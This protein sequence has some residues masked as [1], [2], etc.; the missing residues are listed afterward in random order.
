MVF[1][2]VICRQMNLSARRYTPANADIDSIIDVYSVFQQ[3]D[4]PIE[5]IQEFLW[6]A[7]GQYGLRDYEKIFSAQ[8]KDDIF[9]ERQIDRATGCMV[10][11]RPDQHI[12]HVLPLTAHKELSVFFEGFMM[13]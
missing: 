7:K 6:L 5:T 4:L 8:T 3:R 9:D 1:D 12:A 10:V 2:P 11:V 13:K